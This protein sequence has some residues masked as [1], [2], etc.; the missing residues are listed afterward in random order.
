MANKDRAWRRRVWWIA[1]GVVLVA[2]LGLALRPRAVAVETATVASGSLEVTLDEEGMTRVRERFLVSAPVA[3]R[4]LRQPLEPGDPV[5]SGRTVLAVFQPADPLP[6]DARSRAEADAALVAAEAQLGRARALRAQVAGELEFARAESERHG[7]LFEEGISSK[8]RLDQAELQERT[9]RDALEAAAFAVRTAEGELQAARARLVQATA[10]PG[11]GGSISLLSPIDGVVLRRLRESEAVVPAGE[12]LV[13]VGD[14]RD[15][16]IVADY[17]SSDAVRISPGDRARV[18]RWGGD[19]LEAV[20]QRVEPAGFTKISAL[21]VEEQRVNVVLDLVAPPQQAL[22]DGYRVETEVI[23]WSED[24]VLQV[25]VSGIFRAGSQAA[26]WSVYV[27]DDD[28][29]RLRT[30]RLGQRNDQAAQVL[31]GLAA[32]DEVIL[33]AGDDVEDGTRVAPSQGR[34]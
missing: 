30:V 23:V 4:A 8:E 29:A 10:K 22:G 15:L 26:D 7:E 33:H 24:E 14:P 31:E 28:V 34:R 6:L 2:L 16:E 17:L 1:G 12:P 3:G 32:G 21:G 5:V 27:V 19:V 25:P 9:Q 11:A 20:V 18:A 13:E